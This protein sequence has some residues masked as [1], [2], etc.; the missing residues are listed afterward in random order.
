MRRLPLT[1]LA[2]AAGAGALAAGCQLVAGVQTDGELR[3]DTSTSAGGAAT[4]SSTTSSESSSSVSSSMSSSSTY[5]GPLC[6]NY[7]CDGVCLEGYCYHPTC[8]VSA[9]FDVYTASELGGHGLA[10]ISLET[11]NGKAVVAVQD[12]ID[13]KLRMRLVDAASTLGSIMDQTIPH[14]ARFTTTRFSGFVAFQGVMNDELAEV[15]VNNPMQD[16]LVPLGIQSFGK[17]A[18]CLANE[19]LSR[20]LFADDAVNETLWVVNCAAPG[21]SYKL[22]YGGTNVSSALLGSAPAPTPELEISGFTTAGLLRGVLT[23]NGVDGQPSFIRSGETALDL[24]AASPFRLSATA[25]SNPSTLFFVHLQGGFRRPFGWFGADV[26]ISQSTSAVLWSGTLDDPAV[27]AASTPPADFVARSGVLVPPELGTALGSP[28]I[29]KSA[30]DGVFLPRRTLDGL[31][32]RLTWFDLV[33]QPMLFDVPV[34]AVQTGKIEH[35]ALT[36]LGLS[37]VVVAWIETAGSATSVRAAITHCEQGE[38]DPIP[39]TT[40]TGT[41]TGP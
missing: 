37:D 19:Q 15:R 10:D 22:V 40:T 8:D 17:P 36:P 38:P 24:A 13:D 33:G 14:G 3:T 20:A 26:A 16:T 35:A 1:I 12:D 29:A 28:G 27:F 7:P 6:N 18:Q 4:A 21:T 2:L 11:I 31:G 25:S 34:H 39:V 32:V 30:I 5:M 23:G 41:T 9:A